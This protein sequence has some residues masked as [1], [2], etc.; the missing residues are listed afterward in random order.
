MNKGTSQIYAIRAYLGSQTSQ[1]FEKD[2]ILRGCMDISEI[3]RVKPPLAL[4]WFLPF[5]SF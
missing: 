5:L 4:P 2:D 1:V 3:I